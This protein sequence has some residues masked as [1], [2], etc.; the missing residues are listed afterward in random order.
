MKKIFFITSILLVTAM[1]TFAQKND[2]S[3]NTDPSFFIKS[4]FS[5]DF[6]FA[7]N[8]H[9]SV[10]KE[11]TKVSFTQ[12]D[13]KMSAFYDESNQLLGTIQKET[14]DVLPHNAKNEILKDY[15]GY[16][17]VDIV[18]FEDKENEGMDLL[19]YGTSSND[20]DNYFL[21]LKND[22]KAIV[23]KVDLAGEVDYMGEMK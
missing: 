2:E 10:E 11:F 4:E 7:E 23:V 3:T 22:L 15:A 5:R 21:E 12:G 1:V 17:I 14:F 8:V 19:Q 20:P 13:E 16:R 6:P 18:K 9:Y